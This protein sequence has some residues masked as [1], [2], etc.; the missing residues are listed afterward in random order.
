MNAWRCR[1]HNLEEVLFW[2]FTTVVYI[3]TSENEPFQSLLYIKKCD[4]SCLDI[5]YI[6]I[7]V[8]K[9]FYRIT[10][11]AKVHINDERIEKTDYTLKYAVCHVFFVSLGKKFFKPVFC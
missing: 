3:E 1:F 11:H 6:L 4:I 9:I 2:K 5:S 7:L 8:D 10:I